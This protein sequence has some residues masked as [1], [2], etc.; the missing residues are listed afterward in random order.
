MRWHTSSASSSSAGIANDIFRL[1]PMPIDPKDVGELQRALDD[2]AGKASVLWTT[3]I[4]FALYLAIA[5]GSIKHR[6]LFLHTPIKLPLLNVDLPLVGFFVVAP[7]VLAIFHFYVFLQ[8]LALAAKARYY[9]V[10]LRR[11]TSDTITTLA[12]EDWASFDA[13]V[14]A[15]P[16]PAPEEKTK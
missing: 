6:E 15:A 12:D 14:A 2:V 1:R 9:D 3:F 8:L 13:L 10:L 7:T 16:K 5:F 4:T 11:V